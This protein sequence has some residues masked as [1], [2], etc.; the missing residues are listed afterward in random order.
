MQNLRKY[1]LLSLLTLAL[2]MDVCATTDSQFA[3]EALTQIRTYCTLASQLDPSMPR[4]NKIRELLATDISELETYH[5][6]DILGMI[7]A[8]VRHFPNGE[9]LNQLVNAAVGIANAMP[10]QEIGPFKEALQ[11]LVSTS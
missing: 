6:T 9:V 8:D 11:K 5:P 3:D 7:Y 4:S 1:S 2:S 10:A